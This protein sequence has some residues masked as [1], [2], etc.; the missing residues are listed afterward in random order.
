MNLSD[1][2]NTPLTAACKGGHANVVEELIK[3]NADVN[4]SGGN[5]K[6]LKSINVWGCT[7]D[8]YNLRE[9]SNAGLLLRD[10]YK[11]PLIAACAGGYTC[12]VETLIEAGADVNLSDRYTTPLEIA[13]AGG[14]LDVVK[15][16]MKHREDKNP[17]QEMDSALVF[18][19]LLSG[20]L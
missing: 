19:C 6:M 11:T 12:I 18:A 7:D 13:S 10:I 14:Y 1:R 15:I 17:K 4:L 2:E 16:L 3:A 9:Y 20:K 8:V 5:F